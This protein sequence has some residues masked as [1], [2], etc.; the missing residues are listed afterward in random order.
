MK[1]GSTIL[2][3][4]QIGSQAKWKAAGESHPKWPKMQKSA[5][6]VLASVFWDVQCI[7]FIDYLEKRRTINS[8]YYMALLVF[9]KEEIGKKWSQTKKKNILFNQDNVPCH[10]SITK[11]AKLH[12]LHFKLLLH[13]PYCPNLAPS[14]YWLFADPKG[15]LQG[16][17]FDSNEEVI[18]ETEAYFKPKTNHCTLWGSLHSFS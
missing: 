15:M 3:L 17:R 12:E 4:S 16:K 7:L 2:L 5:G 10:K 6:K 8:E 9:L 13:P 14:N 1:H 18:L 11:M